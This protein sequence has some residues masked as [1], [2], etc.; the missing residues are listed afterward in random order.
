[1]KAKLSKTKAPYKY[2]VS[3]DGITIK[4]GAK[5]YSD[6]TKHKDKDRRDR[7]ILRHKARENW[8]DYRTA[9]FWSRWILWNKPTIEQSI[10]DIKKRFKINISY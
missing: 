10:R 9:G 2:K 8:K 1:M 6:Y 3:I 4:F 5:G 7:Y